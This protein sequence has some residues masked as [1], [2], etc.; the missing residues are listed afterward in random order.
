MRRHISDDFVNRSSTYLLNEWI[1]LNYSNPKDSTS[2]FKKNPIIQFY[3]N[4]KDKITRNP[5]LS[6]EEKIK[7]PERILATDYL[8]ESERPAKS[9]TDPN[10]A[11]SKCEWQ[12]VKGKY[13]FQ[14]V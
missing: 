13:I 5:R 3:E 14:M 10:V 6:E 9:K 8:D 1:N 12:N 11:W 7:N 4:L 2:R